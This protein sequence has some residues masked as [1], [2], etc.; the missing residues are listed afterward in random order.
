VS[1]R[2]F[3]QHW[4]DLT[5]IDG[6]LRVLAADRDPQSR[7]CLGVLR[8]AADQLL[9]TDEIAGRVIAAKGFDARDAILRGAIREQVGSTVTRLHRYGAIEN[10][11]AR[12][13]SK[14][15]LSFS[16][17]REASR[18]RARWARK[19]RLHRCFSAASVGASVLRPSAGAG[20]T[21]RYGSAPQ[22]LP[23]VV[24]NRRGPAFDGHAWVARHRV[25]VKDA[26]V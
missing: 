8:T 15:K 17:L 25:S 16:W 4:T 9:S 10:V 13:A 23:L 14:W 19:S 3:D 1:Q 20:V 24:D 21:L 5:H 11:G 18:G 6:A 22:K 7:L 12:R 2:Q 26:Q